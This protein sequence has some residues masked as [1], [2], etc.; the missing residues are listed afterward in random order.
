MKLRIEALRKAIAARYKSAHA[1]CR[2]N[3]AVKRSSVYAVLS[4]KYAGRMEAQIARIEAA[5]A[6]LA[7]LPQAAPLL[8]EAQAYR[9]LQA[10][11]CAHCRKL[12]KRAC[13]DC[14][15]QTAR[16]AQAIADYLMEKRT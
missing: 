10:S 5:L 1:F 16:E 8:T 4:G 14:N 11:K 7:P 6:G 12:D 2:D 9:V 13:P 15:T 3:P